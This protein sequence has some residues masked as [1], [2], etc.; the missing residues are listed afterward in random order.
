MIKKEVSLYFLN[1]KEALP[2]VHVSL[3]DDELVK[4]FSFEP[5]ESSCYGE[6]FI[7]WFEKNVSPVFSEFNFVFYGEC[8]EYFFLYKTLYQ[9]GAKVSLVK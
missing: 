2:R 7:R 3:V 4:A 1:E 8:Q 9:R 5:L 6:R